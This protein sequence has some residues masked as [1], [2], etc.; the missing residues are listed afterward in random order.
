MSAV[1]EVFTDGACSGHPGP[2]GWAWA[3]SEQEY[4]H[5]CAQSTTSQRM[6]LTA[7]LEGARENV[8]QAWAERRQLVIVTDSAYV[9][10]CFLDKWYEGWKMP[11][12]GPWTKRRDRRPVLNQDLWRP[13]I[14]V[15]LAN[16]VGFRKVR[17]HSGDPMND[18]VDYLAV[19]A[20]RTLMEVL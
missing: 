16:A 3:I 12:T 20:K 10:N 15:V 19:T 18:Y 11:M 13:L 9:S 1:L 8:G 7:A 5:G 6:E 2:G 4:G 14:E 17:G